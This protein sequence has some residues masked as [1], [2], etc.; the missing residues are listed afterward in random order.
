MNAPQPPAVVT[1]GPS[2][3]AN[4]RT[5]QSASL[6]RAGE[7][8]VVR[9]QRPATAL[10][11]RR[12]D[13]VAARRERAAGRVGGPREHQVA[14]AAEEQRGRLAVAPRRVRRM[15]QAAGGATLGAERPAA[16]SAR[17]GAMRCSPSS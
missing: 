14:D 16:R 7:I 10:L 2:L 3:P 17:E 15:R 4:E 1:I 5:V 9:V 12:R 6:A 13:A 11:R 8:A